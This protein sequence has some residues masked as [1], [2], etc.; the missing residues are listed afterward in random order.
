M[1][2]KKR[3]DKLQIGDSV[4]LIKYNTDCGGESCCIDNRYKIG[5]IY[6]VKRF[7]KTNENPVL[8]GAGCNFPP[9]CLQKV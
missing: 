5:D 2:W 6:T 3:Y 7:S 9:K 4:K 8:S 1:N